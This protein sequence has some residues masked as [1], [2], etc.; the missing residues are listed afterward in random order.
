M[1]FANTVKGRA[2]GGAHRGSKR[3]EEEKKD[4]LEIRASLDWLAT[5][6]WQCHICIAILGLI[7]IS[8]MLS[9]IAPR[10]SRAFRVRSITLGNNRALNHH[11]D[12]DHVKPGHAV[13]STFDLFSI[14]GEILVRY[15]TLLTSLSSRSKQ[16]SHRRP[17]AR[18]QNIHRGPLGIRL[19]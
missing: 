10:L 3:K 4:G 15:L 1:A 19:A 6:G 2:W 7:N 12:D 9:S 5:T 14:G 11:P 13:I 17:H 8:I 16:L 18:R